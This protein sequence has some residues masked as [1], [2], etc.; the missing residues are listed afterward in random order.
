MNSLDGVWKFFNRLLPHSKDI[1]SHNLHSEIES[2]KDSIGNTQSELKMSEQKP[3]DVVENVYDRPHVKAMIK[4]ND[5]KQTRI[6]TI[7]SGSSFD[8]KFQN[9]LWFTLFIVKIEDIRHIAF[10]ERIWQDDFWAKYFPAHLAINPNAT[11]RRKFFA[12]IQAYSNMHVS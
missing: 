5:I 11:N 7:M 9:W 4:E 6:A 1:V 3:D 8:S 10:Q 12:D 2:A